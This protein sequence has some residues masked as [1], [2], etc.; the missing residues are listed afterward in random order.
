MS[1]RFNILLTAVMAN[2]ALAT[3]PAMAEAFWLSEPGLCDADDGEIEEMDVIYLTTTGLSSHFFGCEW[4]LKAGE[5]IL[6]GEWSVSTVASC[7]NATGTWE[8]EFEIVRQGD[9]SVRVFQES[10]GISPVRFFHCD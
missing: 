3:V 10:G 4:P 2:M 5:A 1:L 9:G 8:A 7:S 6:R